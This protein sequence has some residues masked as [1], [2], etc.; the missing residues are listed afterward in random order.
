MKANPNTAI[1]QQSTTRDGK[2]VYL[3][4]DGT[5]SDRQR[6]CGFT[7]LNADVADNFFSDISNINHADIPR[8]IK[9]ANQGLGWLRSDSESILAQNSREAIRKGRIAADDRRITRA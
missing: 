2:T 5:V 1:K 6:T 8:A 4:A 3:H 7:A 9:R